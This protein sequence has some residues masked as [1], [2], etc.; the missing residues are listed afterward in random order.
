MGTQIQKNKSNILDSIKC[1]VRIYI[2]S[3]LI[4]LKHNSLKDLKEKVQN[5]YY[6][7]FVNCRNGL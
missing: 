1:V 6:Y 4:I 3:K 5:K 7:I 2:I